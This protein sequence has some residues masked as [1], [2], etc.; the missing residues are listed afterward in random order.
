MEDNKDKETEEALYSSLHDEGEHHHHHHHSQSQS[1]SKTRVYY[2]AK[3]RMH[4]RH[5]IEIH[6]HHHHHSRKGTWKKVL[7]V[8]GVVILALCAV[9]VVAWRVMDTMGARTLHSSATSAAPDLSQAKTSEDAK[10]ETAS[11]EATVQPENWQAGWVRY[12]GK[13]YEYNSDIMT[14]LIMGIDKEGTVSAGSSGVD[15]GQAD[16]QFLLVLNPDTK[17]M[18]VIAINRNTMT[19]VDVYDEDGNFVGTYNLQICLAHGYGDGMQQSCERAEKSVSNLFYDLP[20]NGYISLNMGGVAN[21]VD[22]VGGVTVPRIKYENE[23][24]VYGDDQ[25]LSGAQAYSYIRSRGEDYDSASYR[26][27]KQKEFLKAFITSVKAKVVKDPTVAI[28]LLNVAGKYIVTD[29]DTN[30]ITY[31]AGQIG[32][33]SFDPTIYAL[34]GKTTPAEDGT[35]GHEEFVYDEDE[36]YDLMMNIFYKEVEQ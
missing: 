10:D 33:Y 22:A 12:N 21:L 23:K 14:F 3:G 30:E 2:D 4:E 19:D 35:T 36:L 18:Q 13:V 17:K 25:T 11:T 6:R 32:S 1:H 8:I 29:V 31:L 34:K 5:V 15:G 27:E 26:L 7:L 20:I 9:T 24:L 16:G 28:S